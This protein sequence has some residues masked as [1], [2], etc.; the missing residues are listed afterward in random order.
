MIPGR[1]KGFISHSKCPDHL[2]VHS[3]SYSVVPE[4]PSWGDRGRIE[5]MEQDADHLSP[6]NAKI[7]NEWS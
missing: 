6:S 7:K 2:W 5:Q 4:V 1:G 3:T